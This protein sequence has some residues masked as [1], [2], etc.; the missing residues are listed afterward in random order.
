LESSTGLCIFAVGLKEEA[1]L[2]TREATTSREGPH[3]ELCLAG[4]RMP[5]PFRRRPSP[6]RSCSSGRELPWHLLPQGRG[7]GQR[8]LHP[9]VKG[10]SRCKQQAASGQCQNGFHSMGLVAQSHRINRELRRKPSCPGTTASIGVRYVQ[11]PEAERQP[12]YGRVHCK[13]HHPS[14][15]PRL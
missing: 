11:C 13:R 7:R 10:N 5:R 4:A 12:Q 3:V 15:A 6:P 9:A 8:R 1:S 14:D 2:S